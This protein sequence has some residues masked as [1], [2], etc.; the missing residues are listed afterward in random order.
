VAVVITTLSEG[1]ILYLLITNVVRDKVELRRIVWML[2]LAGGLMATLSIVQQ[3]RGDFNNT[4]GGFAQVPI[5]ENADNPAIFDEAPRA[6]GPIGEKNYYAQF[7]LLLL[8]LGLTFAIVQRSS[9]RRLAAIVTAGLIALAI[10]FTASRAAVVT[11]V[12]MVIA[13]VALRQVKPRHVAVFALAAFLIALA[14][15]QLR[16][17][18]ATM[19][20]LASFA[21]GDAGVRQ[22]DKSTQGRFSE[23]YAAV[24]LFADYP[25]QGVG[26]GNFPSQFLKKAS[27]LG[28]QIH[29]EER[30]AHCAALEIAAENGIFGLLCII[31]II[32]I[33]FRQLLAARRLATDPELRAMATAFVVVLVVLAFSSFFLSF[34]YVRY[35]WFILALSA[36]AARLSAESAADTNGPVPQG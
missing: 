35:Y 33:S 21:Q 29:T 28:F 17:R 36:V 4:Y 11:G 34:A 13:M 10:A 7:L 5:N 8:P 31:A 23:M 19:V 32:T 3:L 15:P 26:P 18:M 30:M 9:W 20:E 14:T 22:V 12:V 6:G 27:A 1:L 25:L 2:L 16:T 24:L